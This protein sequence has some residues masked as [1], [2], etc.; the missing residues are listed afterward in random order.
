MRQAPLGIGLL[1]R[2]VQEA[3]GLGERGQALGAQ[4]GLGDHG[5][6][7][8]GV[9]EGGGEGGAH[10]LLGRLA[11]QRVDGDGPHGLV[12]GGAVVEDH[13]VG[14]DAVLPRRAGDEDA[15]ARAQEAAVILHEVAS[16]EEEGEREG[17]ARVLHRDEQEGAAPGAHGPVA[18]VPHG[19]DGGD[20]LAG[21]DVGDPGERAGDDVAAR[22]DAQ[23]AVEVHGAEGAHGGELLAGK[24]H[25]EGRRGGG[26]GAVLDDER[27]GV[28]GEDEIDAALAHL[29]LPVPVRP[30]SIRPCSI[31]SGSIRP[32]SIR[33]GP[34]RSGPVRSGPDR[35]V[36]GCARGHGVAR[37][38]TIVP[39]GS[40]GRRP[41]PSGWG[42]RPRG[43]GRTCGESADR[44]NGPRMP[45]PVSVPTASAACGPGAGTGHGL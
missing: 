19:D 22:R 17:A 8:V 42:W 4:D 27:I 45:L 21:G 18:H 24:D 44:A 9:L 40:D 3:Q 23:Q 25:V 10:R 34:V 33:S 14:V 35:I 12:D 11:P 36:P 26:G 1:A 28:G 7:D 2:G 13:V 41:A 43:R 6:E 39:S 32:D 16:R 20:L 30:C 5:G 37:R 38:G 31:W 29:C 15:H